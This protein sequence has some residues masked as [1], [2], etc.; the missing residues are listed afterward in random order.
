M[1]EGEYYG[2]SPEARA[3][4]RRAVITVVLVLLLVF[5]AT[6]Y[7]L[8]YLTHEGE[9]EGSTATTSATPTCEVNPDQVEVNVYNAT[10][11]KGLAKQVARDLKKRGF[12]VKTIGNDP[13][14][15]EVSGRGELRHGASGAKGAEL[16]SEHLGEV[17]DV[18]DE[19][20]RAAVD[21]VVGPEYTQLVREDAAPDC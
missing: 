9:R 5:Y 3:R 4:R 12:D 2:R 13:N 6:W 14:P 8:S 18:V 1:S 11:R 20:G 16:V 10:Q 15:S 7:A 19:R 21:V 17:E